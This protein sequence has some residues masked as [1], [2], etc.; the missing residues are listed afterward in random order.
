MNQS[1]RS[2]CKYQVATLI[3]SFRAQ[4]DNP[5]GTLDDLQ[6]VFNDHNGMS[7]LDQGVERFKQF[8]DIMEVQPGGGFI[9][10]KKCGTR[11]FTR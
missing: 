8:P 6:I 10:N 3:A 4:I 5:I 1:L 2:T 11:F 7:L 9:E